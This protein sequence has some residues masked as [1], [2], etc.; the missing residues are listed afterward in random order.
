MMLLFNEYNQEFLK[1]FLVI[2]SELAF[3]I[4]VAYRDNAQVN[5]VQKIYTEDVRLMIGLVNKEL[6]DGK[7]FDYSLDREH[8]YVDDFAFILSSRLDDSFNVVSVYEN[9]EKIIRIKRK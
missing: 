5:E 4:V 2:I 1:N 3:R 7:K 6:I 8:K 9:C